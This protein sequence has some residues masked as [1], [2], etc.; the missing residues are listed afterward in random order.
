[1]AYTFQTQKANLYR[2]GKGEYSYKINFVPMGFD[3]ETTTQ[4][5]KN[6]D[7][8]VVEHYT[9]M[10]VWQFQN[11]EQTILGRNWE[12]F[13]TL[14]REVENAYC[15]DDV[16]TLV[17]IHNQNFE[18]AFMGK[19]L[20]FRGHTVEVFARKK[21][22]PMKIIVDDKII[23]IDSCKLTGFSLEQMAKNYCTTKKMVG[24]LDYTIIRNQ[25]TPLSE[26]EKGYC[27]NDVIIL[28]EFAEYFEETFLKN[29]R[30]PMTSTMIANFSMKDKIKELKCSKDVFNLMYKMYPKSKTEYQYYMSFF[31]GA[32]THGMLRNL[33]V[34]L[35]DGLAWDMTSQY[36][37]CVLCKYFPMGKFH[38]AKKKQEH[39][40]TFIENYCCLIDITFKHLKTKTGVTIISKHKMI[41][42][43]KCKYDNGRL[44]EGEDVRVRITELDYKTYLMHY[45]GAEDFT[46][47]SLMYAK[48]GKL[49]DYY[50]LTVAD[51]FIKKQ[52]LKH[53]PEKK[54]EYAVA[55]ANLNGESYGAC[56]TRLNFEENYFSEDGWSIR[57][58]EI[59]FS[60]LW[61]RKDKLPQ[62]GVY[63]TSWARYMILSSVAKLDPNDYWY[64]DTDSIKCK[65]KKYILQVFESINESIREEVQEMKTELNLAERFPENHH[66]F[67]DLGTFDREEDIITWKSLGSKKY[68]VETSEGIATT[69]A[70]LP[71]K[72]Y[73]EW[74][75]R[76]CEK[77]G[78]KAKKED[79]FEMFTLGGVDIA[80]METKKLCAY[81]S[82]EPTQ[83][84]VI[85]DYGNDEL[86]ETQSYVSLIPT[87]FNIK[88]NPELTRLYTSLNMLY[89]TIGT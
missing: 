76:E 9:N 81:Y 26:K 33:F 69:I 5:K 17:F 24:D 79:Y 35:H 60:D 77:K 59:D 25:Y 2:I 13:D 44:Y 61:K 84:H 88:D 30:L 21:R 34:T 66:L 82:D 16:K 23:F 1:M 10:Y 57:N 78:R 15:S 74:V 12:Q 62:W 53:D 42:G 6:K 48:R 41:S 58:H 55:K 18:F 11:G 89:H 54:K 31:I 43:K 65:N 83:F 87:S 38:F 22:H 72:S 51:L 50:R 68:I 7:G 49:P 45:D 27:I 20:Q 63:I 39:F 85:D 4:Y 40:Q 46:V 19:E 3:I 75:E 71:K 73:I 47:N 86:V 37:F 52:T 64:S 80:D 67:D 32:Y 56:V 28:K 70:G 36:P 14:I 8:E 29:G